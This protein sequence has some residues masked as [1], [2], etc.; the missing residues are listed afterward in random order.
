MNIAPFCK[1]CSN[2]HWRF[3]DCLETVVAQASK[4][5]TPVPVESKPQLQKK[6][7]GLKFP[8]AGTEFRSSFGVPFDKFGCKTR[9]S[10]E[11]FNK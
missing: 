5:E 11:G 10:Q 6:S 9:F 1:K 4:V 7:G 2:K 8:K 3:Q